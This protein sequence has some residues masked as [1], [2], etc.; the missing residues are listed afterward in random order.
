ML[1]A[2]LDVAGDSP[3]KSGGDFLI[4][5]RFRQEIAGELFDEEL[6]VRFVFVQ[7]QHD[8]FALDA[9]NGREIWNRHL[10][11]VGRF[12]PQPDLWKS[13]LESLG[14]PAAFGLR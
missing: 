2:G 8:V 7:G 5:R 14:S 3:M 10:P 13:H 4:D 6:V 9:Y 1:D 12:G 11:D